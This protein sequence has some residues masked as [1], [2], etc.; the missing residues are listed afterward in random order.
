MK[1]IL[2]QDVSNLGKQ[3]EVVNVSSGYA[4]N[5]LYPRDLAVPSTPKGLKLIA[6]VQKRQ[7]SLDAKEMQV[8]QALAAKLE[9][10]EIKLKVKV[11]END[12]LFGSVVSADIAEALEAAGLSI[13]KRK[14][15]L[16]H[17]LKE[18]GVYTVEVKL[19]PQVEAKVKVWLEKE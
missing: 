2:K 10:Q 3:G 15:K 19:H 9:A 1:I 17:P 12:K 16:E 13:D 5:F 6:E 7:A 11:G 14:I 18:L 4:R 8:S